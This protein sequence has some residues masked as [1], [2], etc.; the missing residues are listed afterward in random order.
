MGVEEVEGA[1]GEEG[2]LLKPVQALVGV[3]E[4]AEVQ[5]VPRQC[6]VGLESRP[7]ERLPASLA[8]KQK[9]L[10]AQSLEESQQRQG[11]QH[12]IFCA[13]SPI[14]AVPFLTVLVAPFL[15]APVPVSPTSLVL[16]FLASPDLGVPAAPGVPA[17]PVLVSLSPAVLVPVAPSPAFPFL[18]S[19]SPTFLFPFFLAP[20]FPAPAPFAVAVLAVVFFEFPILL[21][22]GHFELEQVVVSFV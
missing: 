20:A 22:M 4:E 10:P 7:A 18:T 13:L 3:V 11:Q 6:P 14:P 9:S 5:V 15:A 16:V 8:Q 17:V 1:L 12:L 19:L 2:V 21:G